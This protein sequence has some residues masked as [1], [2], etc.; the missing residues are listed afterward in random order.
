MEFYQTQ[1]G[2]RYYEST[3]P[4]IAK[5]LEEIAESLSVLAPCSHIPQKDPGKAPA[6]PRLEDADQYAERI[7]AAQESIKGQVAPEVW[8]RISDMLS[9]IRQKNDADRVDAYTAGFRSAAGML[10]AGLPK[11]DRRG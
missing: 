8:E 1:Q 2:R 11:P 10:N 7:S 4:R 5:S 9:L 6:S 3:L